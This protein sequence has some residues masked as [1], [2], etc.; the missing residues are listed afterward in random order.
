MSKVVLITGSSSGIGQQTA[1]LFAKA[2]WDVIVTHFDDIKLG[3]QTAKK[4]KDLGAHST[5]VLNLNLLSDTSIKSAVK[6]I[7]SKYGK[8]DV[9]VNNAGVLAKKPF[10]EHTP[11]EIE[12]QLRTNLEGL[13]KMTYYTLPII[14]ET[15]INIASRR[16][17][18]AFNDAAVYGAAKWGVRG[19][20]KDI[21]LEHKNL[22]IIAVNPTLTATKMTKF[23]GMEPEKVA[24]VVFDV[25]TGK[26]SAK[27]GD[28]VN[29]WEVYG[30]KPF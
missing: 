2:K 8:I 21:A 28:D 11:K 1:Y 23:K 17:I 4:C 27:S 19:F 9:L 13:V 26:I 16:G 29:V 3:N 7:K 22:R 20:T 15:I 18:F 24:Q 5:F 6:K 12:M 14:K 30:V 25:V 10:L